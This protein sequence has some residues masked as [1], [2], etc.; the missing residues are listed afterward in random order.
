MKQSRATAYKDKRV[1]QILTKAMQD[2]KVGRKPVKSENARISMKAD[3]RVLEEKGRMA[4]NILSELNSL[5]DTHGGASPKALKSSQCE[6]KKSSPGFLTDGIKE[7]QKRNKQIRA[8]MDVM[9]GE[10]ITKK[11]LLQVI[12]MENVFKKK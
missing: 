1:P 11:S 8:V 7:I 3:L 5:C 2:M 9:D 12:E 4:F 6:T 10:E